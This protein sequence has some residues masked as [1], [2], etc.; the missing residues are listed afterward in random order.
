MALALLAFDSI[1]I[2]HF[3]QIHLCL[4]LE[5]MKE[6]ASQTSPSTSKTSTAAAFAS[7]PNPE[8]LAS[9]S[10]PST[11]SAA[12]GNT[13][14]FSS[15]QDVLVDQITTVEP[16]NSLIVGTTEQEE[17]NFVSA[18]STSFQNFSSTEQSGKYYSGTAHFPAE[19]SLSFLD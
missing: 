4:D 14:V 16:P 1:G 8:T 7:T 3:G 11:F 12:D 5:P 18:N 13:S 2:Y 17:D 9:S 19:N 10:S 6:M 15:V